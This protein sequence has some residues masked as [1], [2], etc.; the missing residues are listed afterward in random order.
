MRAGQKDKLTY[1]RAEKAH[2]GPS[3]G[4]WTRSRSAVSARTRIHDEV[5]R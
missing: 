4:T 5:G 2:A 3:A 1:R